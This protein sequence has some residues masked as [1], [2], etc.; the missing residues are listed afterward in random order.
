MV[1]TGIAFFSYE[2]AVRCGD[3]ELTQACLKAPIKSEHS[4][5]G[6]ATVK[7]EHTTS[8]NGF[9]RPIF[10]HLVSAI[11]LHNFDPWAMQA[12]AIGGIDSLEA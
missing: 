8:W 12:A 4:K 2:F 1:V 3:A 7:K 11:R 10:E 5:F 6:S 9:E